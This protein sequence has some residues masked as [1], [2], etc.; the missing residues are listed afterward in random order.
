MRK[1]ETP[2]SKTKLAAGNSNWVWQTKGVA[3]D[4]DGEG[5]LTSETDGC[6]ALVVKAHARSPVPLPIKNSLVAALHAV[7]PSEL[8]DVRQTVE[9]ADAVVDIGSDHGG[10]L[11]LWIRLLVRLATGNSL[12]AAF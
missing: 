6:C 5:L 3:S 2:Q 7:M 8:I 11:C 4:A 10:S 9:G 1:S 12:A